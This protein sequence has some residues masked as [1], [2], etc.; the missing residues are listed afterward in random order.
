M[1]K[2]ILAFTLSV[3]MLIT[4]AL[5]SVTA[6][7]FEDDSF[8]ADEV[9][10]DVVEDFDYNDIN[11]D[12]DV[13][14][15]DSEIDFSSNENIDS[16]YDDMASSDA[17]FISDEVEVFTE[18]VGIN[19]DTN[20]ENSTVSE[21]PSRE[22][23]KPAVT[24]SIV[25]G[26]EKPLKFYPGKFYDFTVTGAGMD[27]TDPIEN[28]ERWEPLYWSTKNNPST[29]PVNTR[30][31]IGSSKGI[32]ES[33]TYSM[34][35]FF[36]KQFFDCKHGWEYTEDIQSLRI[37]F[38]SDSITTSELDSWINSDKDE[39]GNP[40]PTEPPTVT[41]TPPTVTPTPP[42]LQMKVN[43]H[44][45]T[46]RTG[47]STSSVKVT[48]STPYF[49]VVAWYSDNTSIAKVNPYG[50]ITAGKRP[51]K[52]YVTVVMSTGEAAKIKVTVQKGKIKTKSI[53]G[54]K[55][56]VSVNKGKT[57]KLTPVLSPQTS[58][59]KIS[60]SSSN[61]KVA[62][63]SSKGIIKGIKAGT[64]KITVK[65]GTKKFVVTVTVPKTTTKKITGIKS[66]IKLKKGKT[67][68]LKPNK[69]PANSD[70]KISYNSSNKKVATV[71]SKGVITA[72][73]KGS[74]TITINSGKISVKCKVTVK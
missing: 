73:K 69:V 30:W 5:T 9:S 17:E 18:D 52:T 44:S 7:E 47:Q 68:K 38:E 16:T 8:C 23:L 41:P 37:T 61:K 22:P 64:T 70:Y 40:I 50:K 46:L 13:E 55:K 67:Y 45:I 39:Y 20:P 66:A 24:E 49:R 72:R 36:K 3:A 71:S 48:N 33:N 31:R 26:L 2:K 35:I 15:D 43:T 32:M 62:T 21:T 51:G 34:Y 14:F 27:N 56:K 28:D 54:L 63:V 11:E 25:T 10:S 29:I 65:S 57:L 53:S 58:Q 6:A 59:E 1:K 12:L 4:G 42:I 60:Y 74:T 19:E